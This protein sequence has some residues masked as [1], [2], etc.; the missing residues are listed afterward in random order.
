MGELCRSPE[1]MPFVSQRAA[2]RLERAARIVGFV[3]GR[4]RKKEE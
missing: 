4:S 1:H 2:N 3:T